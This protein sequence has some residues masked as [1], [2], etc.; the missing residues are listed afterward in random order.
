MTNAGITILISGIIDFKTKAVKITDINDKRINSRRG[1]YTHQHI[2]PNIGAHK[3]IQRILTDIKGEI[4]GTTI[5]V[6]DPL[7]SIDLLHRKSI[8]QQRFWMTQ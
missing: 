2:W 4:D 6:G 7:R 3:Y 1:Y 8:R 5:I